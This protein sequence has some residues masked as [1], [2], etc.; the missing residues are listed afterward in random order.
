[1]QVQVVLLTYECHHLGSRRLRIVLRLAEQTIALPILMLGQK[2]SL[3]IAEWSHEIAQ[4]T[5]DVGTSCQQGASSPQ[6]LICN[7]LP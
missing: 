7:P 4:K 3:S 6:A 2:C 1:L 5:N